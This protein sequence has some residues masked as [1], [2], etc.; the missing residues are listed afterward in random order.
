M[1]QLPPKT[2]PE[3]TSQPDTVLAQ[4][5]STVEADKK[6]AAAYTNNEVEEFRSDSTDAQLAK[7]SGSEKI[8]A[9]KKGEPTIVTNDGKVYPLRA[10]KTLAIPNDPYANQWWVGNTGLSSAWDRGAGAYQTTVAVIDTGLALQ[11]E[12]FT[13]RWHTNT[14]EQGPTVLEATNGPNCTNRSLPLDKSCNGIDNDNN[15]LVDDVRG[16][17][18][19][20]SDNSVQ[21]GEI[22]PY[23][24]GTTHGTLVTG[25]LAATGNNNT[26]IAGVNWTT[27]ILPIQALDDDGYGNTLTVAQSVRYA[28]DQN[29]DV[30]NI[31]LGTENP[32]PY[33]R[34]AISYAISAGSIVVAASGNDGCDCIAYP[35]NYPEVLAVGSSN[36]STA[37]S[38]F[39]SYGSNIDLLAP[40]ENIVSTSWTNTKP[41]NAY[42]SGVAGTSFSS[43]Y[44]AGI[45]AVAKSHQPDAT[46]GEITAALTEESNHATLTPENPHSASFGFGYVRADNFIERV[47][48]P[49]S[50]IL[51]YQF[52]P[53]T[54]ND[55]LDS[56]RIYQCENGQHPTTRVYELTSGV[57]IRFTSSELTRQRAIQNGWLSKQIFYSCVGLPGDTITSLRTI[58]LLHE[59][60]NRYDKQ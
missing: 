50:S 57:L 7:Y 53:I 60:Y 20:N 56:M 8:V 11:H 12:E 35:A 25:V 1:I 14:S 2:S 21:A 22:N 52:G 28:A 49:A 48:T 47:T 55:T 19:S 45:L 4:D 44:V 30:I 3:T 24:T 17:D 10:Y 51:R 16:W 29:A 58:N 5:D 36:G 26:G 13:G 39:S 15:G 46:W 9:N 37:R 33:L 32:D 40:G 34:E 43:P 27:K 18:F 42:Q 23:G 41:T 59:I 6:K 31:S 38:S 54:V